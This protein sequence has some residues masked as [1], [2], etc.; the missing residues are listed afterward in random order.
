MDG[1]VVA[2]RLPSSFTFTG[3]EH[4]GIRLAA[5]KAYVYLASRYAFFS[6]FHTLSLTLVY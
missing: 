1:V 5:E 6:Y 3:L 4:Q 2:C